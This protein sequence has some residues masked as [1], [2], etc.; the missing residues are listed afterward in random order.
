MLTRHRR[1]YGRRWS[2]FLT[3][4]VALAFTVPLGAAQ[5]VSVP[6]S[7]A[8]TASDV[9][10]ADAQ[11]QA[12]CEIP[13]GWT[14]TE[15]IDGK[16]ETV[17]R[18]PGGE[19]DGDGDGDG[20]GGEQTCEFY[21]QYDEFCHGE[22]ACWGNDPAAVKEPEELKD[23]P[24]PS[25]EAHVAYR[26]CRYPD[27][28]T[29]TQWYWS[30]QN[31][32]PPL[33][34]QAMEAY[35]LLTTPNFDLSF[36]PPQRTYVNLDTWWWADGAGDDEITGSSAFSVVA[37]A[38]PDHIEVDP[39]DG[40]GTITCDWAT[41]KS[42]TCTH[43]YNQASTN[44]DAQVN[45]SPAYT[46]SATLVYSVRFENGGEPLEIEG[47]PTELESPPEQVEVPVAEMQNLVR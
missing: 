6:T 35:G 41:S 30:T 22:A 33:E 3:A 16:V 36:N 42:D 13:P 10:S 4:F 12:G 44:G 18:C 34:E 14:E 17:V 27:G 5:A 38:T 1:R 46:A 24:K 26:S 2:L 32:E 23:V 47:L 25:P 15:V 37:I 31:E 40:S 8:D 29:E 9:S 19:E 39:G 11:P 28:T 45:G 7:T 43:A 20:G 21:E